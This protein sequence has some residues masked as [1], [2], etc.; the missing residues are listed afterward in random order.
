MRGAWKV[1]SSRSVRQQAAGRDLL[2]SRVFC[3]GFL[4]HRSDHRVVG[5][6]P[7]R[8]DIPFLAVP[9]LDA[10]RA[11]ALVIGAGDLDRLQL[12]LEA[13]LLKPFRSQVEVF[14]AP[15]DLL[16]GQWLLA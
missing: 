8:R 3:R 11:R 16:A 12:V 15:P 6:D 9:S 10:T 1:R 13:K 2:F 4:H 5:R 7:I 14:E